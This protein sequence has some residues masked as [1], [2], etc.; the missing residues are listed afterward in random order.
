MGLD[1]VELVIAIEEEFDLEIPDATAQTLLTVG[2]IYTYLLAERRHLRRD[3]MGDNDVFEKLRAIICDLL[4]VK[5]GIVTL[6]A[7]IV[8][9]LGAD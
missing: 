9:D 8:K 5:L 2:D 1:T 3:D 4:G 6:D 7:Y